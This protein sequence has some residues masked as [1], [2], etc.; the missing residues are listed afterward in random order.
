MFENLKHNAIFK[1]RPL[2]LSDAEF[3]YS[4]FKDNKEYYDIFFDSESDLLKWQKRVE[5]FIKQDDIQH[6]IIEVNNISIGWFSFSDE[7]SGTREIGIFVI[8]KEN[9]KR[10]YGTQGLSWLIDKSKKDNVQAITLSVN[11][12]N[13][14]AIRF[15]QKFGFEIFDE[16]IIPHCNEATNVAQY[17]M[18]LVLNG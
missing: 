3:L 4:I 13:I 6:Y 8:S 14:R 16:E 15:Y 17:K 9:L 2:Q 18:K 5:R 7:E 11:Q 1:V 10:G 12:N